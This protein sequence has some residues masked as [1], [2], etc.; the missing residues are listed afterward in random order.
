MGLNCLRF[1]V[2][3]AF[4]T[5]ITIERR[6]RTDTALDEG[7]NKRRRMNY[8]PNPPRQSRP[9]GGVGSLSLHV[10]NTVCAK[11]VSMLLQGESP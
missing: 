8:A 9:C 2:L 11:D 6:Q 3:S 4:T 5:R 1:V 7:S 10:Y